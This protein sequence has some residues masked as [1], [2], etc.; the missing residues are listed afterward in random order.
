MKPRVEFEMHL[1]TAGDGLEAIVDQHGPHPGLHADGEMFRR[2]EG[3]D[4]AERL[5]NLTPLPEVI[6]KLLPNGLV[7]VSA[8][9][10][11]DLH[12]VRVVLLLQFRIGRASEYGLDGS[13]DE[14]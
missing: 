12:E 10:I 5:L 11:D 4:L 7:C 13:F 6:D 2:L 9:G 8:F 3:D 14:L 1:G